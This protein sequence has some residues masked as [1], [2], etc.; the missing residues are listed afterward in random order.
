MTDD[1]PETPEEQ[2]LRSLR[3]VTRDNIHDRYEDLRQAQI[4]MHQDLR[5]LARLVK[6]PAGGIAAVIVLQLY[7]LFL[8]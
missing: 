3:L 6:A 1:R 4:R 7:A 8:A 5:A 2:V